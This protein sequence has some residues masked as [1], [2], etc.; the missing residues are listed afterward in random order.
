MEF[1][2]RIL[3]LHAEKVE[4][5]QMAARAIIIF[6]TSLIF[7]R[8]AGIRTL[9]R[10]SAFD[11]LTSLML[12]AIM[13]RAVVTNQSFFGSILATLVLM[14][15]HRLMAWIAFRSKK[16]G[17]IIK[18]KPLLLIKD[19][20]KQQKNLARSHIT[21][22]DISE[23]LRRD[24]NSTSFDEIKEVYLERSGEISIIKQ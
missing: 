7:L 3:G 4:A 16:A 22:D 14:L 21:E 6:F 1:F 23:A 24:V 9:G 11:T 20:K 5:Y 13:G 10:Q 8:I 15:L 19:G 12:G 17:A 2:D 18:G